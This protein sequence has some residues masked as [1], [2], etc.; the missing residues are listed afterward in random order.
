MSKF[1]PTVVFD[2]DG[3]IHSYKS[4]W[5][6]ATVIPDPPVPGIAD[7]IAEVRAAGMRAVVVSTRCATP[8]GIAAVEDYL[9]H[10]DITVD[11]VQM[12]KPP[13]ICYVDDRAICFDGNASTLAEKIKS[14]KPWTEKVPATRIISSAD[15]RPCVIDG[16]NA[17]F[18]RWEEVSEIVY[19]SLM[20]G[21]H[22][23]GEMKGTLAI[24]EMEDGCVRRVVPNAVRFTDNA[25]LF[26]IYCMGNFEGGA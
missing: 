16:K 19:P 15:Y 26:E 2:F 7:A 14:F 8:E 25:K 1:V 18:H 9:H 6:G 22:A 5:Q 17:L 12:E 3:V 21:G 23:G 4:G 20:K 13:A 11:G 10:N 24:V